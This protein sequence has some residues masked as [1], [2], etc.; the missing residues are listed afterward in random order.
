MARRRDATRVIFDILCVVRRGVSKT[1]LMYKANLSFPLVQEYMSFLTIKGLVETSV[2]VNGFATYR[3][4]DK[5][6]ALLNLLS[7]V[8]RE[9]GGFFS[10]PLLTIASPEPEPSLRK[11]L[12]EY[13]LKSQVRNSS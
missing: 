10:R 1:Q 3:L 8:E 5:G 13:D 7:Q 2:N 12:A 9:L 4:T 6:M 11:L